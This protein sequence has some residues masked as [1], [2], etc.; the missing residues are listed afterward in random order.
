[1]PLLTDANIHCLLLCVQYLFP[2]TGK[3]VYKA[4]TEWTALQ[5]SEKNEPLQFM[6]LKQRTSCL[7]MAAR[8]WW[9]GS[10]IP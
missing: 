5:N 8:A 9:V 4:D 7:Y 10:S 1:M 2:G 6:S 3:P